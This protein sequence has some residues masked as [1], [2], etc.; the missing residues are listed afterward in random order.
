[1]D[2]IY[3]AHIFAGELNNPKTHRSFYMPVNDFVSING[4]F[5]NGKFIK[6]MPKGDLIISPD[7][8]LPEVVHKWFT[9]M[10]SN[11]YWTTWMDDW[12]RVAI[13]RRVINETTV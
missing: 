12:N 13:L 11:G 2:D 1:M 9:W 4:Y 3:I 6:Y 10:R 5:E 7:D 8:P